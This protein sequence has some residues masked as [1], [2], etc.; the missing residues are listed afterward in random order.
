MRVPGRPLR[1]AL[2]S[3]KGPLYR[4]RGGIFK[5]SLRYQPLTLTTLAALVPPDL[6][7]ELSLIDEGIADVPDGLGADLIGLTVITGT[8]H[9]AYELSARFRARG[10]ATVLGGPHVTL[11]PDDARPHADAIVTGYAEDTW[12]ELLRDFAA[13]RMKQRYTQSPGLEIGG[14]P[15]PRR[16]LL[17]SS[18][19]L[20]SNVFEATRG[21]VHSCDFC[22][23]PTAW[24]KKPFQKPVEEVVADIRQH[25]AR[26]LIFIDLNLIAHRGYAKALFAALIPLRL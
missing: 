18:H 12:P 4:H 14:R 7:V 23:V 5:K 20:T 6:S 13:G 22:V 10:A 17:P 2:I 24:G 1:L 11:I 25:G 19:F 15:F 9:R 3:P 16:D 26:K 8:A 21:C